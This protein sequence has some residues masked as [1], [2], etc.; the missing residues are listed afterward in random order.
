MLDKYKNGTLSP[1][2]IAEIKKEVSTHDMLV[3]VLDNTF[4]AHFNYSG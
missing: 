3:A 2:E 4:E 1:A